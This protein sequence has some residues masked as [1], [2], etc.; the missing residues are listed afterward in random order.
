MKF[1]FTHSKIIKL[2]PTI[3]SFWDWMKIIIFRPDIA[4]HGSNYTTNVG[5]RIIS[6]TLKHILKKENLSSVIVSRF[7]KA[8]HVKSVIVAGGGILHNN[9]RHNLSYRT[10]MSDGKKEVYYVGI[11]SPG[12]VNIGVYEKE[13]INKLLS[14]KYISVRD[15]TSL[16]HLTGVNQV[17]IDK[18][19][20]RSCPAWLVVKDQIIADFS[21]R[22]F[23]FR[24]YFNFRFNNINS[25][26][27]LSQSKP[28]I[29]LV[30][31]RHFDTDILQVIIE[32]IINLKKTNNLV[33]IPFVGEDLEFYQKIIRPLGI[34]SFWLG[35]PG[36]TFQHVLQMDKM[37][38]CRYHSLVLSLLAEK[39][40]SILAYEQKVVDLAEDLNLNFYD[41][42][43]L[44]KKSFN[45]NEFDPNIIQ[46]KIDAARLQINEIIQLI[47]TQVK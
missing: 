37:I 35:N 41:A 33:F 29:G 7:S 40:V 3:M 13:L 39:P 18:V 26:N 2:L 20:L 27:L 16:D 23:F 22:N 14:A 5:D 6:L 28:N 32:R 25:S 19:R 36:K 42:V 44:T 1:T 12:L 8:P 24:N 34:K 4:I 10:A 31:N 45:F 21:I 17:F 43:N 46:N 30:L 9:Y 15:K 38:A 47:K 11:G